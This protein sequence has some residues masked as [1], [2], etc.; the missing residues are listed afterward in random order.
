MKIV[1]TS[2]AEKQYYTIID[3]LFEEFGIKTMNDFID[4][5]ENCMYLIAENPYCFIEFQQN[6]KYRKGIIHSN[7]SFFYRVYENEIVVHL[8]WNNSQDPKKLK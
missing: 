5:V 1:W 2:V 7:V 3:Y 8:F 4:E 6:K